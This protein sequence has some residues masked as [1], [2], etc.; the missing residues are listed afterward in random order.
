L[1]YVDTVSLTSGELG[2]RLVDALVRSGMKVVRESDLHG[3]PLLLRVEKER[4]TLTLRVFLWRITHGGAT[5]ALDEYRVQTTRPGD[6]PFLVRGE[7]RTLLLGYHESLEVFAAWDARLHRDPASSSSLQ[8]SLDELHD[9]S[10]SGFTSRLRPISTGSEVVVAFRP[11]S[12]GAYLDVVERLTAVGIPATTE[13]VEAATRGSAIKEID[14]PENVERRREIREV[15][16]LVRDR[17]FRTAVLRAYDER[18][19][20]C[21]LDVGLVVAAH[22]EGVAEGG[23]DVIANGLALC[24]TH[25]QAFDR[26]LLLIQDDGRIVINNDLAAEASGAPSNVRRLAAGVR[27]RALLPSDPRLRPDPIRL[28]HHRTKWEGP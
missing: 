10:E 18:C 2:Q 21:G 22:I 7:R 6:Q 20:A 14:L 17:R 24:P 9:A 15:A 13:V 4:E 23:E 27:A 25:H 16:A 3:R 19:A 28:A 8:V 12:A 1:N 11:D 5:R 26:G